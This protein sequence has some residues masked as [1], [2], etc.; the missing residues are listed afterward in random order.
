MSKSDDSGIDLNRPKIIGAPVQRVED[1]RLL[2]GHG[3][4]TDDVKLR[5]TLH[6]ALRRS[7]YA[8][9]RIGTID[10]AEAE[11]MPGVVGVF[12]AQHL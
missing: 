12:T 11:A 8:H 5:G 3:K 1:P 6:V 7:D 4:F 10:T 2:T 9:A